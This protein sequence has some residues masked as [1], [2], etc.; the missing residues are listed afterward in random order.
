KKLMEYYLSLIEDKFS[1]VSKELKKLPEMNKRKISQETLE[2]MED[3][4]QLILEG[5]PY[6]NY[7]N[8]FKSSKITRENEVWE[9]FELMLDGGT[10]NPRDFSYQ[11]P[12]YNT[13]LQALF[14]IAEQNEFKQNDTLALAI[15]MDNG[16]YI[17]M[18]DNKVREAV[19]KDMNDLLEFFRE[20]NLMQIER[21]YYPLEDYPLEAKVA[22]GWTGNYSPLGGREY[23]LSHYSYERLDKEG[24]DW[25]TVEIK[26]LKRMRTLM[27]KN[28]WVNGDV[29]ITVRNIEEYFY[30]SGFKQHWT[31]TNPEASPGAP[32]GY[33]I[34]DGK[35]VINHDTC[36]IDWEFRYII[37]NEKGLGDCGEQSMV[38]ET[39]LKS[40]GIP[41]N[42]IA[43][44]RWLYGRYVS[45][46]NAIY[47]D[48]VESKWKAYYKQLNIF[49]NYKDSFY[50]YIFKPPIMLKN[51][52]DREWTGGNDPHVVGG[53]AYMDKLTIQDIK[54][55]FTKGVS[56]TQMKKWLLYSNG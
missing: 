41:A 26:T 23:H 13:E 2:A 37:Q 21:G 53:M 33:I 34:I 1:E 6:E 44:Q 54:T 10:P 19:Y 36:N 47:F 43:R 31:Y 49:L 3:I 9:A 32:E 18:G 46:F 7:N 28:H 20:T 16:L 11:V 48:P 17:T 51:Y 27:E 22:L 29:N 40:W 39:F 45:H 38:V 42:Y 8:R 12:D 35:S 30:F 5:Q 24:Y 52:I 55:M 25:N 4:T 15:A 14:W 50:F 56:T